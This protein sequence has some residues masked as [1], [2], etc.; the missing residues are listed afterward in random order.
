MIWAVGV[1]GVAAAALGLVAWLVEADNAALRRGN[2]ELRE[3]VADAEQATA[4]YRF[5][6]QRARQR[7]EQY[8]QLDNRLK[9]W[10]QN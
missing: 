5:L 3:M 10:D 2:R 6:W 9:A 7:V 4:D 1:L 8:Q